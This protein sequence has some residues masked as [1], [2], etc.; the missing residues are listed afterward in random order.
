MAW[1]SRNRRWT[2]RTREESP[3]EGEVDPSSEQHASADGDE[4]VVRVSK[5]KILLTDLML[6]L[7]WAVVFQQIFGF[8]PTFQPSPAR[9]VAYVILFPLGILVIL[10]LIGLFSPFP[11]YT[12][13][14][15]GIQRFPLFGW[16]GNPVIPWS[17]VRT[18]VIYTSRGVKYLVITAADS[19]SIGWSRALP[20]HLRSRVA[21]P[22]VRITVSSSILAGSIDELYAQIR[23][24]YRSEIAEYRIETDPTT[25]PL[26]ER[27]IAP[28][29]P[30]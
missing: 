15:E 19:R 13:S 7:A 22:V 11:A 20:Q 28:T 29:P 24:R 1:L 9:V 4:L 27:P 30:T 6:T 3:E 10:S 12:V 23:Q 16:F 8:P 26:P 17:E 25:L 18:I 2:A 14:H 5:R 21:T